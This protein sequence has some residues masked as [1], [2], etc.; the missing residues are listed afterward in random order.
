MGLFDIF[1]KLDINT[2]NGLNL[3]HDKKNK[4]LLY[5][6][7][8]KNGKIDGLLQIFH[9]VWSSGQNPN[10]IKTNVGLVKQEYFFIDGLP[11]GYFK[12][13]DS[14]GN[15][16]YYIENIK[17]NSF[18]FSSKFSIHFLN[19]K[20]LFSDKYQI[21]GFVNEY[22][23]NG[24]FSAVKKVEENKLISSEF[25]YKNGQLYS[26]YDKKVMFKQRENSE[27]INQIIDLMQRS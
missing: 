24:A 14:K 9:S 20:L 16:S 19:T 11:N 2:N 23:T 18:N 13:F 4:N 21:N 26:S 15:L 8:K 22:Y 17:S 27:L 10:Y 6:F 12:E 5:A 1:N 7:N 3:I 25:Y